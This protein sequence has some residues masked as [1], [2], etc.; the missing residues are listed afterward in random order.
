MFIFMSFII[1][2]TSAGICAPAT[3][4]MLME[5][6]KAYSSQAM[7]SMTWD[8][9]VGLIDESTFIAGALGGTAPAGAPVPA[10]EGVVVTTVAVF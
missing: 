2:A 3:S 10:A 5:V 7:P 8:L 4:D 6:L 1:A 9:P